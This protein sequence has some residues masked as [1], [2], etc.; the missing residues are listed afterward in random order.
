[1]CR[2]ERNIDIRGGGRAHHSG[3]E[4]LDKDGVVPGRRGKTEY[5]RRQLMPTKSAQKFRD[6]L[7]TLAE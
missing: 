4:A 5:Q 3:R 2:G 6:M 1:V 7:M